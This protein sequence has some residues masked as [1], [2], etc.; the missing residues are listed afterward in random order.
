MAGQLGVQHHMGLFRAGRR[1]T[2]GHI[3]AAE[4]LPRRTVVV[5][6]LHPHQRLHAGM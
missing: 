6:R 1:Q 4:G 3:R 5:Q 2:V